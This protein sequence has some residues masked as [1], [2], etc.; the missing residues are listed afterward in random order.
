MV[1]ECSRLIL[2][3]VRGCRELVPRPFAL[4]VTQSSYEGDVEPSPTLHT[5]AI[6]PH[7]RNAAAM[8]RKALLVPW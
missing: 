8:D 7:T 4:P 5:A 1:P 3:A 2:S 6:T